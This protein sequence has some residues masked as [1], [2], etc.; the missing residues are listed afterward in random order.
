MLLNE[1]RLLYKQ[2]SENESVVPILLE[3]LQASATQQKAVLLGYRGA[4]FALQGKYAWMPF[5]KLSFLQDALATLHKAIQQDPEN[6]E[7]RF[8]RLTVEK[9][10]PMFLGMAIHLTEDKDKILE[11]ILAVSTEP[12]M[13]Q[14]IASYILEN[15]ICTKKEKELLQ[16]VSGF[17]R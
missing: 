10:I 7:I 6:V 11:N 3:K 5:S 9:N 15:T 8:L 16:Q 4:V 14:V 17:G 2:A 1:I 12:E 13:R